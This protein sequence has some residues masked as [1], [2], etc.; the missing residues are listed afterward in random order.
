[1]YAEKYGLR[2]GGW[3]CGWGSKGRVVSLEHEMAG[4]W[5]LAEA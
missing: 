4:E 1:M 3:G 2:K 5:T